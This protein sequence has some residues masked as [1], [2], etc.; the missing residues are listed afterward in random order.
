MAVIQ[1]ENQAIRE[2]SPATGSWLLSRGKYKTWSDPTTNSV[3]CLWIHGI[4][5]AG[6]TILASLLIDACT[7]RTGGKTVYF[8]CQHGDPRRNNF[9]SMARSLLSQL[10]GIEPDVIDK[11]YDMAANVG[12]SVKTRKATAELLKAC[13]DVAG[14]IFI[15]LD[16]LDECSEAERKAIATWLR[17]YTEE[18]GQNREPSRCVFLSQHDESTKTLLSTLPTIRISSADNQPDIKAYCVALSTAMKNRFKLNDNQATHVAEA[19]STNANG[20]CKLRCSSWS[21]LTFIGMF[22]Y[23]K[24]VMD[25][26][27]HQPDVASLYAEL[28][29]HVFPRGLH[30]AYGPSYPDFKYIEL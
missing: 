3:A 30:Q 7:V 17:K 5:G 25:N 16:G 1:E 28:D 11:L 12:A 6:K 13:L 10:C 23:A 4:P 24:L 22:L 9:V 14:P 21:P 20:K 26:L 18:S 19:V 8:Y 29:P 15:V 2:N 27:L